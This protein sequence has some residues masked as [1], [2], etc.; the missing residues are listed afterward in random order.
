M[1]TGIRSILYTLGR[2]I[3]K[4]AVRAVTDLSLA[5]GTHPANPQEFAPRRRSS[6]DYLARGS[7]SIDQPTSEPVK[8]PL[9]TGLEEKRAREA[10]IS[11]AN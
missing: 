7:H 4:V 9:E 10:G 6:Q 11:W 2:P 3:V 1:T 5:R 8:T